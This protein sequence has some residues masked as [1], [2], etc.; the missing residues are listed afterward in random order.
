MS[1]PAK[2]GDSMYCTRHHSY[3]SKGMSPQAVLSACGKPSAIKKGSGSVMRRIPLKQMVYKAVNDQALF[4]GWDL[5]YNTWNLPRGTD[6]LLLTV[7][8]LDDKIYSMSMNG[9]S[10]NA[11]SLCYNETLQFGKVFDKTTN[12]GP[13]IQVGDPVSKIEANCGNP[14]IINTVYINQPVPADERPEVWTYFKTEH[15]Q[16]F[17]LTFVNGQLEVIS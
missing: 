15:Q 7:E 13:N 16:A 11:T 4:Q 17:K 9:A 10:T 1:L 3:I 12:Q 6:G 8:I 2:A 5:I 14:N